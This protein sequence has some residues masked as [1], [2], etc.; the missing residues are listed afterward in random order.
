MS[1]VEIVGRT[2][3]P[4]EELRQLILG[5]LQ[6]RRVELDTQLRGL[7]GTLRRLRRKYKV[8]WEIF[9]ERF[10]QGKLPEDAD[11]DYVDWKAASRLL[12]ELERQRDQLKEVLG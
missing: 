7:N 9:Q 12:P 2:R 10:E 4:K 5:Q 1:R 3:Y 8:N 6:A 11:L